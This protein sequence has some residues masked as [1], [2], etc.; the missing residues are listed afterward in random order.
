MDV[1]T[2]LK[3]ARI[4]RAGAGQRF[5]RLA[6]DRG[7]IAGIPP[8]LQRGPTSCVAGATIE[9]KMLCST[10]KAPLYQSEALCSPG[11]ISDDFD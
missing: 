4:L 2:G 6:V 5:Q 9:H 3:R 11:A 8:P 1:A 10:K 7:D